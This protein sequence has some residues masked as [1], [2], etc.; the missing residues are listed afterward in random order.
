MEAGIEKELSEI[1]DASEEELMLFLCAGTENEVSVAQR[2]F[3]ER[4]YGYLERLAKKY[5]GTRH[6]PEQEAEDLAEACFAKILEIPDQFDP[7]KGK[8]K[9]WIG[10]ILKN[11]IEQEFDRISK[12]SLPITGSI[13]DPDYKLIEEEILGS[14][15][16]PDDQRLFRK[17]L[18]VALDQLKERDRQVLLDY[19]DMK[20]VSSLDTRGD[21][22]VTQSI[23][24]RYGLTQVNV[25]KIVSRSLTKLKQFLDDDEY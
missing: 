24:E 5:W 16:R 20:D 14:E 8:I 18:E 9:S 17:R 21:A 3:Y 13:D 12:I 19:Y 15:D 7:K 6:H 11:L 1:T 22:G 2:E 10:R 4:F 25:R 23:A